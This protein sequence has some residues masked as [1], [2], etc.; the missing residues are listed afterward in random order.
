MP[1]NPESRNEKATAETARRGKHRLA[2]TVLLDPPTEDRSRNSEEGD[3]DAEDPSERWL[4]PVARRRM[5][6]ANGLTEWDFKDTKGIDL[7]NRQ[8]HGESSGW[9]KPTVETG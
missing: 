8:V 5:R 3:G 4:A 9:D 7:A 6:H 2:R 1:C